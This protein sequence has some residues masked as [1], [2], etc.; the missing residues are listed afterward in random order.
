[1]SL[2]SKGSGSIY[3]NGDN[4]L[5]STTGSGASSA[6]DNFQM[7]QVLTSENSPVLNLKMINPYVDDGSGNQTF[8][9]TGTYYNVEEKVIPKDN[10]YINFNGGQRLELSASDTNTGGYFTNGDITIFMT[11]KINLI[12]NIYQNLFGFR[13]GDFTAYQWWGLYS[14]SLNYFQNASAT[15]NYVISNYATPGS[16]HVYTLQRESNI[17]RAFRDGVQIASDSGVIATPPATVEGLRIGS[18]PGLYPNNGYFDMSSVVMYHSA[19]SASEVATLSS[20]LL[21]Y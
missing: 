10:S 6:F 9:E 15:P 2:Y 17:Y 11:I 20:I 18:R 8:T 14:D 4:L 16:W 5:A 21:P 19:L 13:D 12:A 3:I 7:S 1:M